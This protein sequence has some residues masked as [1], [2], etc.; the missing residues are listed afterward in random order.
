[1]TY[2]VDDREFLRQWQQALPPQDFGYQ[3]KLVSQ[4]LCREFQNNLEPFGLTPF[5]YLVLA[6]LWQEDGLATSTIADKLK[7]LGATL[8]GV[9]DRM[10]ERGVIRRERDVHDRRVWRTWL[11]AEGKRLQ[12]VLP[13]IASATIEKGMSGISESDRDRLTRILAQIVSNLS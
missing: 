3:F 12:E 8:T 4:L 2:Q 9:L 13:P 7:Q 11:T 10:E 5:H 6:C 1:M